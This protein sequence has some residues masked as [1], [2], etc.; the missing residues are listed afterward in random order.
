ML[1]I[2]VTGLLAQ[3]P[4]GGVSWDYAQYVAGLHQLGHDVYYFEDTG[5]WP[6][7][8]F[9]GGVAKDCQFNVNY[10]A[11][12]L[13]RFGLQEQWAYRFPWQSQWFGLTDR[14]RNDIIKTA[15]LLINVSGTLWR[16]S[17]YSGINR[18]AYIDSDP[19]F[20][21]MKLARGQDDFRQWIDAHHIH[22]SFGEDLSAIVPS[23]GHTWLPTRQPI[24][25]SEWEPPA[26]YREVYTT[27]MNWTSYKPVSY[28]GQTYGQKDIELSRFLELPKKVPEIVLELAVNTGKTKRT[29]RD[30]LARKGWRITHP[31]AVCPDMDSYRA[32]ISSSKAEWSIAKNGYVVG[33]PG[34]FSCRSACYLASGRPVIV[35]DTGFSRI[36]PVGKGIVAFTTMDEAVRAINDVESN[37]AEHAEAA[38]ALAEEYFDSNIVLNSLIE[39]AMNNAQNNYNTNKS[40]LAKL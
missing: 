33:Q 22:F 11:R 4:L 23:T 28:Q 25:L 12:L 40:S 5:Q 24:L 1:R 2:I 34:W 30:L 8:P 9:S 14:K 10:L 3:Y 15:D 7:N 16:P 29:P 31:D 18:L 17:D 21:Q 35:Q 36:F 38:R 13:S 39:R 6:F 27:I 20:T 32:Y 26:N 37:Y 19:V